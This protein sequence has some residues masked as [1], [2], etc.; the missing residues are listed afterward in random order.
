MTKVNLEMETAMNENDGWFQKCCEIECGKEFM[1]LVCVCVHTYMCT[2]DTL[3]RQLDVTLH[4]IEFWS[5]EGRIHTRT[6]RNFVFKTKIV[7]NCQN[8]LYIY[9]NL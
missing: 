1:Y 4:E 8:M 7:V 9:V 3:P 2:P 5:V 6:C